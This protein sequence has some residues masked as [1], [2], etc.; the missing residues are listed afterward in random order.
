MNRYMT[1]IEK[2]LK[3]SSVPIRDVV[4]CMK[5]KASMTV[6]PKLISVFSNIRCRIIYISGTISTPV[7]SPGRRHA[8]GLMPK[9]L[10]DR[11]IRFVP[12]RG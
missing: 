7:I 11:A 3:G 12:R 9:I 2:T 5:S 10:M 8:R 6:P 1:M 4:R